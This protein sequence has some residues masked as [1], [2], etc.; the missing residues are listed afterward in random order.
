MPLWAIIYLVV[1]AGFSIA[2]NMIEESDG[3]SRFEWFTGIV[4]TAVFSSL[5]AGFWLVS[6]PKALGVFG[7][8]LFIC[9]LGFEIY[10]IPRGLRVFWGHAELSRKEQIALIIFSHLSEWVLIVIAGISVFKHVFNA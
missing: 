3:T 4:T 6:I 8:I 2:G 7:P 1:Y 9:A 5:F 10:S